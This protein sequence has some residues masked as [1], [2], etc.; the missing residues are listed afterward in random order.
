MLAAVAVVHC[1]RPPHPLQLRCAIEMRA[2]L[3]SRYMTGNDKD[4]RMPAHCRCYF[5]HIT[6]HRMRLPMAIQLMMRQQWKC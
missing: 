6:L 4:K 2:G 5:L 3:K 1:H